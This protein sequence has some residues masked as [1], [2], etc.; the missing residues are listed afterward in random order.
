MA[1]NSEAK[2]S[3]VEPAHF[4]GDAGTILDK[5]LELGNIKREEIAIANSLRCYK[6]NNTKPNKNELD[7]CFI[8]SLREINEI[9]PKIVVALGGTAMYQALGIED[10]V[11][12]YRGKFLWSDKIQRNVFV[13][14]HPMS[15]AY[16]PDKKK[17][18]ESDFLILKSLINKGPDKIKHY[19]YILVDTLEKFDYHYPYLLNNELFI[20]MEMT[21]LDPFDEN[22]HIRTLQISNGDNIYV[23]LSE[24]LFAKSDKI[25]H[26]M[27]TNP[28]VGQDFAID[29]KWLHVRLDAF[30]EHWKFDTCLAEYILS[31]VG[32]NDLNNLVGKYNRDYY[33]YWKEVELVGGAH[34]ITDNKILYQYGADDTGNLKSI[35]NKQLKQL[36]KTNRI[37][38]YEDITLPSNKILTKMSLRGV[39][40]DIPTL[41]ETDKQYEIK[42]E[43][44]LKKV[45]SLPGIRECENHF[46]RIFNPKSALMIKWLLLDY[47]KLPVIKTT[48]KDN[49]SI[50]K[51]EM[52]IYA[53]EYKNPYCKIMEKYRSIQTIRSNFLSGSIPKLNN[54][55]AHTIYSLHSTETGRP[56]SKEPNLLNIPR[57]LEI[58]KCYVARDGYSFVL[59]DESQLEMRIGSVV[60]DEPRLIAICNDLDRDIHSNITAKAFRKSYDE[61]YNGYKA[62][63]VKWT[64]LRVKG[65]SVGFG[66]FYQQGATSLAYQLGIKEEEAQ[67]FIDEF[68]INFPD[69]YSNIEKVKKL[70]IEQ[71]YLDNYFGFRRTWKYHRE[72]DK[73]TLR[74]AVNEQIQ[75][76]AW[77]LIQLCLIQI[78]KELRKRK[79]KSELIL[80]VYD[81][82]IVEAPDEEID[83]VA[84]IMKEIM[85]NVNKPYENIN[86]VLLATDIEVGK[87]LAEM[88]KIL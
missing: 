6:A 48:K 10:S 72:E 57:D 14:Y 46:K 59:G 2:R 71:G 88:R 52:E 44:A 53:E 35:R 64:E 9:D 43:R 16:D 3:M 50:S 7:A 33:G 65:K 76:L 27:K 41:L 24:I 30:P 68:F 80:Q 5:L 82:I 81:S 58:K 79:L 13:T 8:F 29:A 73:A 17:D 51:K 1:G 74:E 45:I 61:V 31:G 40:I 56:N 55:I 75:S 54:G 60:Y 70:V 87:N 47:Y 28:I 26:L 49:P 67:R 37:R 84:H 83:E 36:Y 21:G 32:G 66:V 62:G 69:L 19:E 15:I 77:N 4:I 42:G 11:T 78:D 20:D 34:K 63:D 25:R 86:R 12:N 38:L 85:T 18:I 23:I 22:L 39:K